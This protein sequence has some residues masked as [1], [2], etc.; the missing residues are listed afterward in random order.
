MRRAMREDPW[1]SRAAVG[2]VEPQAKPNIKNFR[3]EGRLVE[4]TDRFDPGAPLPEPRDVGLRLRLSPT[5]EMRR[6]I[7]VQHDNAV[8][9]RKRPSLP[10][11][12]PR[13]M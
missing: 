1:D 3:R 4:S 2:W 12:R 13:N 8:R 7:F 11:Y 9:I 5:Y 10:P 6:V